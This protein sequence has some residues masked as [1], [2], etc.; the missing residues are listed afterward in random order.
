MYCVFDSKRDEFVV[1]SAKN[2][3][4]AKASVESGCYIEVILGHKPKLTK[5][6]A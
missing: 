5:V 3:K 1:V 4:D 6:L 2:Y